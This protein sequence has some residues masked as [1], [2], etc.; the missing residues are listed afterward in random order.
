MD[1]SINHSAARGGFEN[2]CS[3]VDGGPD[4]LDLVEALEPSSNPGPVR[5]EKKRLD[6][7]KRHEENSREDRAFQEIVKIDESFDRWTVMLDFDGDGVKDQLRLD[8]G[9][10]ERSD[11]KSFAW[12]EISLFK[13]AAVGCPGKGEARRFSLR[14]PR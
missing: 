9:K 8:R 13:G 14:D 12:M 2:H 5:A 7:E 3:V 10:G 1:N 4:F 11:G 6:F